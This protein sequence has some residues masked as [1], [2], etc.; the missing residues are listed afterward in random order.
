MF[1][2]EPSCR[3]PTLRIGVL[4]TDDELGGLVRLSRDR[5]VTLGT[6]MR[7]ALREELAR[8]GVILTASE[9]AP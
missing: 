6:T 9:G 5:G 3:T 2:D 8:A 4:L 1:E 7:R